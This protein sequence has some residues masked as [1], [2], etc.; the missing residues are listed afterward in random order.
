M[1]AF[2]T[3]WA[4]G[5][6]ARLPNFQKPALAAIVAAVLILPVLQMRFIPISLALFF[7]FLF[8]VRQKKLV[9][10]AVFLILALFA[11]ALLAD[12]FFFHGIFFFQRLHGT[13]GL[14]WHISRLRNMSG[15]RLFK[16][17]LALLFDQEFG[18]LFYSP[19]YLLAFFGL[20][21]AFKENKRLLF[22]AGFIIFIYSC[23]LERFG[24]WFGGFSLPSRYIVCILPLTGFLIAK[25]F[26]KIKLWSFKVLVLALAM[27][28]FIISFLLLLKPLW[29]YNR[30]DGANRLL[31]NLGRKF[32]A[33]IARFLPSFNG[34]T[35][36]TYRMITFFI[37]VIAVAGCFFYWRTRWPRGKRTA[38]KPVSFVLMAATAFLILTGGFSAMVL[39]GRTI[40]TAVLEG[41]SMLHST[42][43]IYTEYPTGAVWVMKK[44]GDCRDNIILREGESEIELIAG[45]FASDGILPR[46]TVFLGEEMIAGFDV[47]AGEGEWRRESYRFR[48]TASRGIHRLRIRFENGSTSAGSQRYLYIDKV[49]VHK[50]K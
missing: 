31:Q 39:M 36:S 10:R 3:I 1:A 33:D 12:R 49:I 32:S 18:L 40:P 20:P 26:E 37:V 25:S 14:V 8:D 23:F 13:D 24:R 5:K 34:P 21:F 19:L 48:V 9:V 7:L 44:T 35:F 46:I 42:G 28:S 38:G 6:L 41:E 22:I 15:L 50:L 11:A 4:A 17:A 16:N 29:K 30:F 2:F 27:Y 43:V 47:L 45:G